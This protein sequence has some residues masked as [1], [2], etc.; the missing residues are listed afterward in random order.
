MNL[1][2][3]VQFGWVGGELCLDFANTISEHDPAVAEKLV[4]FAHLVGWAEEAGVILV[5]EGQ[6]ILEHIAQSPGESE[7][8]LATA[9]E[10]RET[11]YRLFVALAKG[12][13]AG[14]SDLTQLNE[15]LARWP[16]TIQVAGR[17]GDELRCVHRA[18][19]QPDAW[20]LAPVA[21]SAAELLANSTLSSRIRQCCAPD[22]E[23]LFLDLSKNRSRR[24][25]AMD[26]CGDRAKAQRYYHRH[27]AKSVLPPS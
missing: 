23:W 10:L 17:P 20:L 18:G 27:K 15:F 14:Q 13:E 2:P 25:C 19:Q 9:L 3:A 16:M 1:F 6:K 5:P 26:D 24:W 7:T 12:Q 8:T 4:S 11:I 21:R 22:C